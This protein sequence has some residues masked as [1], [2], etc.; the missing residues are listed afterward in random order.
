MRKS[1]KCPPPRKNIKVV[2]EVKIS[3]PGF[4]LNSFWS[5]G[6]INMSTYSSKR[7]VENYWNKSLT[8]KC[9]VFGTMGVIN[10]SND[11]YCPWTNT[12][13]WTEVLSSP[14]CGLLWWKFHFL[15]W[16]VLN[17]TNNVRKLGKILQITVTGLLQLKK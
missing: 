8:Q 16:Y 12:F 6:V 13:L 5:M 11:A 9:P 10:E 17:P 14:H 15:S 3:S 1:A 4:V 7:H 2:Q